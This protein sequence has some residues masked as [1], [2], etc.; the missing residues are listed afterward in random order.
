MGFLALNNIRIL[1]QFL[2]DFVRF[3]LTN[4]EI[5][6]AAEEYENFYK[7]SKIGAESGA[8]FSI[9]NNN[10]N[11]NNN[12]ANRLLKIDKNLLGCYNLK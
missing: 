3:R 4:C 10:N 7:K 1:V 2:V 9:F 11:N 6:R 5:F 8:W 12:I